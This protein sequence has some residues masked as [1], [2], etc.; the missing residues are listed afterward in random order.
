MYVNFLYCMYKLT[1]TRLVT[2]ILT[3]CTGRPK[4]GIAFPSSA[5]SCKMTSRETYRKYNYQLLCIYL[6]TY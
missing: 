1:F 2:A 6:F 4:S 5:S 3:A